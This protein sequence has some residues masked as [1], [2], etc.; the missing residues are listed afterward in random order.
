MNNK[1][2]NYDLEEKHLKSVSNGLLYNDPQKEDKVPLILLWGTPYEKGFAYGS[3]LTK[4]VT[5]I[6]C[7]LCT[8]IYSLY[9]GWKSDGKTA[10]TSSQIKTGKNKV[11][12]H[13]Y[14]NL[15]PPIISQTPEYW[16]QIKG[17]YDGLKSNDSPI[18]FDDLL[19]L[20]TGPESLDINKGCSNFSAW[21]S[22]TVDGKMYHGVNL[23]FST[24]GMLHKNIIVVIEKNDNFNDYLGVGFIGCISPASFVNE[25]GISYGEMTTS[26]TDAKWPGLPHYLQEKKIALEAKN[27][28]D[29]FEITKETGGTTGFSNHICESAE[30][31]DSA[32]IETAGDLVGIRKSDGTLPNVIFTTNY[33]N[34]YP[35]NPGYTGPNLVKGQIDYWSSNTEHIRAFNLDSI[36][37][38]DVDTLEKFK[39]IIKC[40][41]YEK[42]TDFLKENYGK[43]TLEKAIEVQSASPIAQTKDSLNELKILCSECEN[44]YGYKFPITHRET[45]KSIYTCIFVPEE[46]TAYIAAGKE[47]AQSGDFYRLNLKEFIEVIETRRKECEN[48]K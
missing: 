40:K 10:P 26:S 21:G 17:L 11:I 5:E 46:L 41:R 31:L 36:R 45:L 8:Q 28:N 19:V 15:V 4:E 27:I 35:G 2:L 6:T 16:N 12:N 18:D 48:E 22:A 20:N 7:R 42:Y 34:A 14:N 37:W 23:D 9:G 44:L 29:A 43:I 33:F 24:F 32:V 39:S 13:L 25:A 38:E 30:K 3:L 47:P 1:I